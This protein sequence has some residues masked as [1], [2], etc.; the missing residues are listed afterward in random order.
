MATLYT[1]SP[2]TVAE[3]AGDLPLP[4]SLGGIRLE[5]RD[6]AGKTAPAPLISVSANQI[7]FLVPEDSEP[8][9]AALIMVTD[10]SSE[11][12]GTMQVEAVAPALFMVS[13]IALTPAAL[14][15]RI[16]PDGA[17]ISTPAFE[18]ASSDQC[19]PVPI[20]PASSDSYL[21]FFGTGFRNATAANVTCKIKGIVVP[22][23][24]AGPQGTPGL[25]QINVRLPAESY[26][27]W[28]IPGGDV[29]VSINGIKA[30]TA[31]LVFVPKGPDR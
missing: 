7:N 20:A 28:E 27:F 4:T 9:E 26:D 3:Q 18:C 10:A 21:S 31:W 24:Y 22:V 15:T 19:T 30:N 13:H 6:S 2:A 17:K 11:P 12:V 1:S 25:D 23:E 8:G 16:E 29:A 5:V 14:T